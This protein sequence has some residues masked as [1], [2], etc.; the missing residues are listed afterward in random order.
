MRIFRWIGRLIAFCILASVAITVVYRV[1]DPPITPLML[2]RPLEGMGDGKLVGIDRHWVPLDDISPALIRSVIAAEDGRFFTHSGV[3]WKAV[4]AARARNERSKSGKVFGASTIT[5]Q[6]ARNIFLWQGRNYVR[7][8]LEVYFTYLTEFL[9]GKRRIIEVYLNSIEWGDGV[10]GAEAAAQKYFGVSAAQLTPR[11]AA[12]MA[13]VLP[14]PRVW[15][16][17]KPTSY[18]S[19]RASAIQGRAAGVSLAPLK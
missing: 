17:A 16:P 5:M 1:V 19:S 15:S 2:I 10:Y 7:K 6:C 3:D 13:A 14:N 11:Q 12:L 18:I 8:G 4:E 9:W